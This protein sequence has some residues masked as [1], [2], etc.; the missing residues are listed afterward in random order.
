M[1]FFITIDSI[2]NEFDFSRA[3]TRCQELN[4]YGDSEMTWFPLT[5]SQLGGGEKFASK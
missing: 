5:S 3:L 1:G 2:F 4:G